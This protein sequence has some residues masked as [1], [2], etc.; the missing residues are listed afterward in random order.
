MEIGFNPGRSG[1]DRHR[2]DCRGQDPGEFVEWLGID[3]KGFSM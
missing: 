3:F 1:M 2:I